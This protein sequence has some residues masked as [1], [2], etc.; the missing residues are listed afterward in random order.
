VPNRGS[1]SSD[2]RRRQTSTVEVVDVARDGL[3]T[4][5]ATF[6]FGLAACCANGRRGATPGHSACRKYSRDQSLPAVNRIAVRMTSSEPSPPSIAPLGSPTAQYGT[7]DP[8]IACM[9]MRYFG[10]NH[11]CG[12][13]GAGQCASL[14]WRQY[15]PSAHGGVGLGLLSRFCDDPRASR[16]GPDS[17]RAANQHAREG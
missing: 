14:S 17:R 2:Y 11:R 12:G 10:R 7:V 1:Q 9:E 5:R 4:R 15:R 8:R 6:Q 16:P 13:D 3:P